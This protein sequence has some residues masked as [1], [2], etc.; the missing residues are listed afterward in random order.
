MQFGILYF[1][2]RINLILVHCNACCFLSGKL[3][4]QQGFTK[5]ALNVFL[6]CLKSAKGRLC[7][8]VWSP[9]LYTDALLLS[10]N[11]RVDMAL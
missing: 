4:P 6:L 3:F 5:L 2:G 1:V 7:N 8:V 9:K 10:A 11:G